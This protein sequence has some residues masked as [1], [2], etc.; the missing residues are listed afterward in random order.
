[1]ELGHDEWRRKVLQEWK[2][3]KE[4]TC[5]YQANDLETCGITK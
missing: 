4:Q 2:G 3:H 5:M 1:M